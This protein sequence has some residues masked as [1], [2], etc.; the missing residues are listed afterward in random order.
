MRRIVFAFAAAGALSAALLSG[1]APALAWGPEG[2]RTIALIA[3]DILTKSAPAARAKLHAVLAADNDNRFTKNDLAS[4]ATWADILMEKS[5]EARSATTFWHYVRMKAD[6]PDLAA[7]CF[8][9]KPLPAGYP[10]SR[11]PRDNCIVDKVEQFAKELQDSRT[12]SHERLAAMRFLL[13]LV[14]DLNDPI[15]AIDHGDRG[16]ECIAIQVGSHPP[17]RLAHYWEDTLVREV[18]GPDPARGA[19]RILASV[20]AAAAQKWAEGTPADWARDSY[21]IARSV[22]YSFAGGKPDGQHRFPERKG[23]SPSCATVPLYRVGADYETKALAAVKQQLGKGGVRLAR[24]L[25]DSLK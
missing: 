1:P 17:V 9:R 5:P 13:N 2:H 15:D 3:G 14:G 25:A 8:G 4:E 20:P 10:A 24:V 18:V 21:E 11:G 22:I 7:A 19:A 6:S 12:S 23:E 16:G